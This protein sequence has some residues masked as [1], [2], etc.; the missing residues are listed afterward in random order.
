MRGE[1]L[2]GPRLPPM[3]DRATE[4]KGTV[5]SLIER[6]LGGSVSDLLGEWVGGWV[7]SLWRWH[8]HLCRCWSGSSASEGTQLGNGQKVLWHY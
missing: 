3:E 1:S 2:E 5:A 6:V 8:G 4:E 7:G